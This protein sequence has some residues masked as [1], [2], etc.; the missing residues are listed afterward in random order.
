MITGAGSSGA[1]LADARVRIRDRNDRTMFDRKLD[2]PCLLIDL[3][4]GKFTVEAPF[5]DQIQ[6]K[7]TLI[8]EG[9]HH[10]MIFYFGSSA[11]VLLKVSGAGTGK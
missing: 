6:R 9:D 2:G 11:D 3:P 8:V 10:Q 7:K 4:L 1:Y 5:K